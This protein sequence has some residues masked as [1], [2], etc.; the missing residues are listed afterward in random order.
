LLH[1]LYY[2]KRS[3]TA[4]LACLL[5][6]CYLTA[7]A[8]YF[9]MDSTRHA[10][11]PFKLVR[12]L[13]VIQ[14][15][16]NNKGHFNF[17]LDTGVGFMLITEPSLA[18]S[19]HIINKR[20]IKISGFGEGKDFEAYTTPP[21]KVE[22]PGLV[23]HN[24]TASILKKDLFNLSNYAGM[25]I[26]GL[27]GYEFFSR[28]AVRVNFSDS[29]INV[30]D[31][32][33]MRFFKR[34]T[35]I[36]ISI[37]DRKPY[38]T[39][40]IVYADGT[41]KSSKLIIDLGAGHFISMENVENKT[42]FEK[43]SIRANLGMGIKGLI[44]GS[45]SRITEVDLGKY[46]MRHLIAAFPDSDTRSLT[47]KRDGNL[48]MGLLKKFDIIFDYPD[49][50]MYLRPNA[51]FKTPAEHDM[52]GLSYYSAGDDYN[53]VIINKV[54]QD[55]P[56]DNIGLEEGDELVSINF[57]PVTKMSLQQIDNLFKSSDGHVLV[58]VIYR[59]EDKQYYRL[60]LIL[61]RRI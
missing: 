56:A 30:A 28:L 6:C 49:S 60:P 39:T 7:N 47:I 29:T 40:K 22:I 3:G 33:D 17:V 21:L 9:D 23:S 55:S 15:K 8:Q 48:G 32:K 61:K 5:C 10:T 53:H 27:L 13:V 1:F 2:I 24:V 51:D 57:R 38:F 45:L 11:I 14:L 4:W 26:D 52:S 41:E 18:D 50:V 44:T 58:L 42:R 25:Q 59:A 34:G 19:I 43:K 54:D 20:T 46:K 36:P 12:N 35:R 31:P 16:I 37:Q